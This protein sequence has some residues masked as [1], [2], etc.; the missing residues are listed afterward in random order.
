MSEVICSKVWVQG[1]G[2][3]GTFLMRL[4]FPP[5]NGNKVF[6]DAHPGEKGSSTILAVPFSVYDVIMQKNPQFHG[7]HVVNVCSIQEPSTNILLKYTDNVTSI[8]PLFGPRTPESGRNSILTRRAF[9]EEENQFLKAFESVSKIEGGVSPSEHDQIMAKTHYI[10]VKAA[11]ELKERVMAAEGIPDSMIPNSFRQ[12]RA[13]VK[14][15][16]DMPLGTMDSIMANPYIPR[17]N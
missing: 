3:F 13:F 15:M 1:N 5:V 16:E 2:V 12:L 4:L 9:S 7:K 17:L 8:H 14:T 6:Y 11:Q 10:A